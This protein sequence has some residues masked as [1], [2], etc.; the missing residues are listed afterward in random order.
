MFPSALLRRAFGLQHKPAQ[1]AKPT[2]P[3][4]DGVETLEARLALAAGV[5][6]LTFSTN[7]VLAQNLGLGG[8]QNDGAETVLIQPEG[9]IVVAGFTQRATPGDFDF[10]VVRYNR[11]GTIDS[12][13]GG[14]LVIGGVALISGEMIERPSGNDPERGGLAFQRRCGFGDCAVAAGDDNAFGARCDR[15]IDMV[16]E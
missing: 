11:D 9:K 13:F 16:F 8:A 10:L 1:S 2:K 6:D 7:G 3:I 4:E 14:L 12:G 5:L 15:L